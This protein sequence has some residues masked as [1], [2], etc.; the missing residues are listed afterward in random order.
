MAINEALHIAMAAD[1]DVIVLGEDVAG[2][3]G[4]EDQGIVDAWA[5][6]WAPPG[7]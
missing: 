6:R 3:G 2:G 7:G 4:R 1:P 5:G